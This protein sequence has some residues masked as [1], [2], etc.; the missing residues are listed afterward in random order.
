MEQ[1]FQNLETKLA[2]TSWTETQD[3][4]FVTQLGELKNVILNLASELQTFLGIYYEY[5]RLIGENLMFAPGVAG[6]SA[7]VEGMPT[8]TS[9]EPEPANRA[10]R[11]AR[12]TPLKL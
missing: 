3:P 8:Q 12:K 5:T 6:D 7:D 11:R 2:D 4:E 1:I 10:E 9:A